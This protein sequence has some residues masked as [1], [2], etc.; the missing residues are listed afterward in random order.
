MLEDPMRNMHRGADEDLDG[1]IRSIGDMHFGADDED[2][3]LA[4]QYM[5]DDEDIDFEEQDPEGMSDEKPY[6]PNLDYVAMFAHDKSYCHMLDRMEDSAW[7]EKVQK[8]RSW[9]IT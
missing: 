7:F 8:C 1:L 3:E 6:N 2:S 5:T 4:S 9:S